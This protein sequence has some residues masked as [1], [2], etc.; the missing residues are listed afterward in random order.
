MPL[1][2]IALF[3]H[4]RIAFLDTISLILVLIM[5]LFYLILN[6]RL[7]GDL[8]RKLTLVSYLLGAL[9]SLVFVTAIF[10]LNAWPGIETLMIVNLALNGPAFIV[11]LVTHDFGKDKYLQSNKAHTAMLL[12]TFLILAIFQFPCHLT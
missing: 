10:C 2:A 6:R 5:T 7:Y 8:S 11:L 12:R 3:F 9:H 4:G 1:T